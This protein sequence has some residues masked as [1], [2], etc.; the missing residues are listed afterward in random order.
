MAMR[1]HTIVTAVAK[2]HSLL[3]VT[4]T[5][6]LASVMPVMAT[7][8]PVAVGTAVTALSQAAH[9]GTSAGRSGV[10]LILHGYLVVRLSHTQKVVLWSPHRFHQAQALPMGPNRGR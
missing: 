4:D 5:V 9:S 8:P 6:M 7:R 1:S 2:G 3:I 10:E